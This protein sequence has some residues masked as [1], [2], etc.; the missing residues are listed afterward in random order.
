MRG[1]RQPTAAERRYHDWLRG[2]GCAICGSP[3]AIHHA[4]GST[5]RHNKIHIGQWWVINLC[6]DHHQGSGGI[7]GDLS[8]FDGFDQK[9][10]GGTRK[11]I[12]KSLFLLFSAKY[13]EQSREEIPEEVKQAIAGYHR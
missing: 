1:G 8:S 13:E 4:V 9:I 3:T 11:E 10:L 12:E 6:Y 7:H 5:G 2:M